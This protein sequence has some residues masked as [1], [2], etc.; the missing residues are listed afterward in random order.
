MN[1]ILDKSCVYTIAT[2]ERL[3]EASKTA[4][5]LY[6]TKRW[7]TAKTLL[8]NA[9][10]S[11]IELPIVFAD[12]RDCSKLIGW[13]VIRTINVTNKGTHYTISNLWGISPSTP[14]D[15]QL[16]TSSNYIAEG[17]VRPY[18]LCRTPK[19][20]LQEAKKPKAWIPTSAHKKEAREGLRRIVM[21]KRLERSSSLIASLKKECMNRNNGRLP[22]EVCGFDFI[23]FY[24][25]IGAGFAEAHHKTALS[26]SSEMGRQTS[27]EDLAIV[28]ANCHQMLHR[29]PDFP[30]ID[31]LRIRIRKN[32]RNTQSKN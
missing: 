25:A 16:L 24:G 11:D 5:P 26:K 22:C 10:K 7:I 23:E 3:I 17:H 12:A 1:I 19:F 21:H 27:I 4:T 8:K 28:C 30:T 9:K 15:L 13:S 2:P 32:S 31:T 6:E 29:S 18:V 20:L 14:Q